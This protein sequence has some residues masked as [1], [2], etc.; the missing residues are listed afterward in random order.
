[1]CKRTRNPTPQALPWQCSLLFTSAREWKQSKGLSADDV[2]Y[3]T[4]LTSQL[5]F[6]CKEK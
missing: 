2:W 4:H 1:M 6:N 3:K 5:L